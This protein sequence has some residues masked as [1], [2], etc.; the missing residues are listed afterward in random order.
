VLIEVEV[1]P[2]GPLINES[3]SVFENIFGV[4]TKFPAESYKVNL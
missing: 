4:V 2:Y 3:T 1:V